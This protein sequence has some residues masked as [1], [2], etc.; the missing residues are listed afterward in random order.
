MSG[1]MW[2]VL[3]LSVVFAWGLKEELNRLHAHINKARAE[4]QQLE[5]V[6]K[7]LWDKIEKEQ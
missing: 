6:M 3:V 2:L 5:A 4:T 7:L 1:E